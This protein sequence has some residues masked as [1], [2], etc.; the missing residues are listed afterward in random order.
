MK[1]LPDGCVLQYTR[2]R[3]PDNLT[4]WPVVT[5]GNFETCP[6][7]WCVQIGAPSP[8]LLG[9]S[10]AVF[11]N[12]AI[13]NKGGWSQVLDS[14]NLI[15]TAMPSGRPPWAENMK[16]TLKPRGTVRQE[17]ALMLDHILREFPFLAHDGS[18]AFTQKTDTAITYGCA[19]QEAVQAAVTARDLR[20]FENTFP[21]PLSDGFA[22]FDSAEN[23]NDARFQSPVKKKL[24]RSNYLHLRSRHSRASTF[25]YRF[26]CRY[27]L[28]H[29]TSNPSTSIRNI[30]DNECILACRTQPLHVTSRERPK[31]T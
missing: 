8:D 21:S 26:S 5:R 24:R 12:H 7:V 11:F 25:R 22:S 16:I 18:L 20:V 19:T 1:A 27:S 13:L 31:R 6:S 14:K 29:S 17:T 15:R 10:I 4:A 2:P 23:K 3:A 9:Q 28:Q 30:H